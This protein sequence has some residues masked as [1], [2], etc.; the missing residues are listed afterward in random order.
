MSITLSLLAALSCSVMAGVQGLTVASPPAIDQ[1]VELQG[2][3]VCLPERMHQLYDTELEPNHQHVYGFQTSDGQLLLLL[4]TK[5]SEALFLDERVR[6]K[7]L[8]L[9]GR[10]FPKS[11]IF[12]VTRT[13]SVRNGKV[14]DLYYYC[15]VCSIE[16]VS[17]GPC[18]C[19]QGPVELTERPLKERSKH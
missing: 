5:Y 4:R 17:P 7:E 19:C 18:A 10:I 8:R 11:H 14:F 6:A 13:R 12:E 1:E 15:S 9:K 2:R 3:V 16:T